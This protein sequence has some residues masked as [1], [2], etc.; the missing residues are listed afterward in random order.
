[1]QTRCGCRS[2]NHRRKIMT[3]AHLTAVLAASHRSRKGARSVDFARL[4]TRP[5]ESLVF[6]LTLHTESPKCSTSRNPN[7][8]LHPTSARSVTA[9]FWNCVR[10]S[11]TLFHPKRL[12]TLLSHC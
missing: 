9:E 6:G 8:W 7:Y 3:H 12:L 2:C 11:Q 1:M 5:T 10:S 4:A